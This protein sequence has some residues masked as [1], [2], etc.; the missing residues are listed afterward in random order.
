MIHH[1]LTSDINSVTLAVFF[2]YSNVCRE[3]ANIVK[4][5]NLIV[6]NIAYCAVIM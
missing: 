5:N 1:S 4:I 2:I 3:L 6:N